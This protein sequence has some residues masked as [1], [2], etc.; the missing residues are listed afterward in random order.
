[1]CCSDGRGPAHRERQL[2]R[3]V[4]PRCV[5]QV[6]RFRFDIA[7]MR[8]PLL[9]RVQRR[10]TCCTHPTTTPTREWVRGDR[11]GIVVGRCDQEWS[12]D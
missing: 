11:P 12:L 7:R 10:G 9:R 2:D 6:Y 4:A 3:D 1:M 8:Y 5:A